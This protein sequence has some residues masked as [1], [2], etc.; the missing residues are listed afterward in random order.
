MGDPRVVIVGAGAAGVGAGMALADAGVDFVILEAA[1]RVGG[2]AFTDTASLPDP[3]DQGCHWFHSADVNPLVAHAERLGVRYH[4]REGFGEGRYW[5]KGRW[6]DE[7]GRDAQDAA[8]DAAVA[9]IYAAGAAGRD[10]AVSELLDDAGD[11]TIGQR[12][13]LQL[14][15][16]HDP[17]DISALCYSEYADTHANWPVID[18]Y[19]MLIAK[20]AGGLPIRLNTPVRVLRERPG[21]VTVVTDAGDIAAGAVIV[22]VSTNVLAAGVIDITVPQARPVLDALAH[23]PC[24]FYEK[25]AVALKRPIAMEEDVPSFSVEPEGQPPVNW[26][27]PVGR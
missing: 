19:G 17:E 8:L 14:M 1:S 12:H 11:C 15:A 13:I 3:W 2:R 21:G 4:R 26:Q 24:G 27:R 25:I 16:S 20:M 22:T 10:V 7:G 9:A 18:G 5:Q 23:V 6:L